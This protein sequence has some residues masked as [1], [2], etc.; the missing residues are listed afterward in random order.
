MSNR[1]SNGNWMVSAVLGLVLAMLFF[2][3]NWGHRQYQT[4]FPWWW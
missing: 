1:C 3:K 2:L 4:R